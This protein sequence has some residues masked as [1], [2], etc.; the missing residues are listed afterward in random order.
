MFVS[1]VRS[2]RLSSCSLSA[3]DYLILSVSCLELLSLKLSQPLD[4]SFVF[5]L[6]SLPV[7]PYLVLFL[8]SLVNC[9][10]ISQSP[11]LYPPVSPSLS[12]LYLFL[13]FEL[14]LP[15]VCWT[16]PSRVLLNILFLL[17]RLRVTLECAQH[18]IHYT[19]TALHP[20]ENMYACFDV[21]WWWSW[22][23]SFV[24]LDWFWFNSSSEENIFSDWVSEVET[25]VQRWNKKPKP[26]SG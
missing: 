8:F 6:C 13:S 22:K 9:L 26:H 15:C 16:S 10:I 1:S 4:L 24:F 3:T 19:S 17:I 25:P 7:C 23:N 11:S 5:C 18:R 20:L 2:E 14:L 21:R 12:A